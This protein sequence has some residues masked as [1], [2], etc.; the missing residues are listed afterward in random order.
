[1][2]NKILSCIYIVMALG[3]L[4]LVQ[5]CKKDNDG[6]QIF[7]AT[8][9]QYEGEKVHISGSYSCWDEGDQVK[10]HGAIGTIGRDDNGYYIRFNSNVIDFGTD[11]QANNQVY[12]NIDKAAIYPVSLWGSNSG[13]FCA[14][15][16]VD[17]VVTDDIAVNQIH[18]GPTQKYCEDDNHQYQIIEAPMVAVMNAA[19][20]YSISGETSVPRPI[21]EF[22]NICALMK[23]TVNTNTPIVVTRIEVENTGT[24]LANGLMKGRPL[25]GN[26]EITFDNSDPTDWQPILRE[27]SNTD[28][29]AAKY[30]TKEVTLECEH[31]GDQG[32]VSVT[33]S[34]PFYI[35]LP[36]VGYQNLHVTV[37][38]KDGDGNEKCTTLVS[39]V[40]S[41]FE[42]NTIY[43]LSV[44][45]SSNWTTVPRAH[46]L[47][48]YTVGVDASNNP[49]R[50]SFSFSNLHHD[51]EGYFFPP[52]QYDFIGFN[53]PNGDHD[54]LTSAQRLEIQDA[55]GFD[56]NTGWTILTTAEWGYLLNTRA[57]TNDYR[58][59]SVIVASVP[60]IILFPDNYPPAN[61]TLPSVSG[62]ND[63]TTPY[64]TNILSIP[65]FYQLENAGCV[66]L[67]CVYY[68]S[69]DATS[70]TDVGNYWTKAT[71]QEVYK[72]S[73]GSDMG[74]TGTAPAFIRLVRDYI[75]ATK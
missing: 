21:L 23:V 44:S 56:G 31:H 28:D 48:P 71:W 49:K 20:G 25:W 2:K 62:I 73:A 45:Y 16:E 67:P 66:F 17:G 70:I 15:A 53:D 69:G 39:S 41:A 51:G 30:I 10:M 6:S 26:F 29:L 27:Q 18:L 14:R 7:Y 60:G 61:A 42:A 57:T 50:V 37:Y 13:A 72:L 35:Y 47:G 65:E 22:K 9:Q 46:V 34:H 52:Y 55:G 59:V 11:Y 24:E 3:A 58:F 1:M 5:S 36:P 64:N 19:D 8:I 74:P 63:I 32:G 4:M 40:S 43:P 75:P 12:S 33:S 68:S 54:H 38:A